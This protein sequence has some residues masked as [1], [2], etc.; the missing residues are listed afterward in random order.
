[1]RDVMTKK[2]RSDA[3]PNY[4][5]ESEPIKSKLQSKRQKNVMIFIS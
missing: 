1:M 3:I 4:W 2:T 5:N